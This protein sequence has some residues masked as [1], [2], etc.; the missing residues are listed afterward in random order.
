MIIDDPVAHVD[1][2]NALAFLN[3]FRNAA[4]EDAQIFFATASGRPNK[5]FKVNF[6][7]LDSSLRELSFLRAVETE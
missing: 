6:G 3:S 1:D 5:L 4:I 7:F 2:L